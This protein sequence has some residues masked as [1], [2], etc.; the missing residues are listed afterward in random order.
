[1]QGLVRAL[2]VGLCAA[3]S[4]ARVAMDMAGRELS[5]W[6]ITRRSKFPPNFAM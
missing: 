4:N 3:V 6:R 1:M 5:L 2:A